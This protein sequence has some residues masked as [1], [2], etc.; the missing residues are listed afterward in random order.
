MPI[1]IQRD[2]ITVK[3]AFNFIDDSYVRLIRAGVIT[4]QDYDLFISCLKIMKSLFTN[5]LQEIIIFNQERTIDIDFYG[6][7]FDTDDGYLRVTH[8]I[9][10][11]PFSS[12]FMLVKRYL[13]DVSLLNEMYAEASEKALEL[14]EGSICR[15]ILYNLRLFYHETENLICKGY[16]VKIHGNE[17]R[18]EVDARTVTMINKVIEELISDYQIQLQNTLPPNMLQS[19]Y[20][21]SVSESYEALSKSFNHC[22]FDKNHNFN[23][24]D[25]NEITNEDPEK[26]KTNDVDQNLP[27]ALKSESLLRNDFDVP[28]I[29]R[30]LITTVK[31]KEID[32]MHYPFKYLIILFLMGIFT[33]FVMLMKKRN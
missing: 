7:L 14:E 8:I 27:V 19:P 24:I 5:I 10:D 12:L 16:T 17:K 18:M 28:V 1:I 3:T 26:Y 21:S 6:R 15:S 23:Y 30:P 4:L 11:D 33:I 25:T 20:F 32:G 13:N 9:N 22:T 2:D 31:T 29:Y